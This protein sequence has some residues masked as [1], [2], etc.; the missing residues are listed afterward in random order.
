MK[1]SGLLNF[2][3]DDSYRIAQYA[4]RNQRFNAS[5]QHY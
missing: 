2:N 1:D 5:V 4:C 3:D